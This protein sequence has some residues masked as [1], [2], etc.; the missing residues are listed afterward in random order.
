MKKRTPVTIIL[1]IIIAQTAFPQGG[2]PEEYRGFG[3]GIIL[4]EP[5][6]FNAKLV[7]NP[8]AAFD[9]GVGWSFADPQHMGFNFFVYGDYLF[10]FFGLAAVPSGSLGFYCGI[11][12]LANI[13]GDGVLASIRIPLGLT[14]LIANVPLDV[15]VEIVPS[16]EVYPETIFRGFGGIGIRYWFR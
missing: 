14:Y 7:L 11:G 8:L 2:E 15:F 13:R 12:G 6:G 3:I 5:T 9:L 4:G 16:M 10:H 1:A